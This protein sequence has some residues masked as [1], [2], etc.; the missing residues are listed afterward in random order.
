MVLNV[1]ASAGGI[2]GALVGGVSVIGQVVGDGGTGELIAQG[3]FVGVVLGVAFWFI[4][5]SDKRDAEVRASE[6]AAEVVAATE[7]AELL[8]ALRDELAA[9]R[10]A[11]AL[12]RLRL[13]AA[14]TPPSK[15]TNQ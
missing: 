9:E 8:K 10:A 3:G 2:G 4:T 6:I 14:L 7:R 5:R 1:A 11:H 13:E 15:G 12:T